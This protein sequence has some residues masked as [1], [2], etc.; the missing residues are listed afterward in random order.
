MKTIKNLS[1]LLFLLGFMETALLLGC[2]GEQG[3]PGPKAEQGTKGDKGDPGLDGQKGDKGETGETGQVGQNGNANVI[4][5]TYEK[6]YPPNPG[7]NFS[8][9]WEIS[10]ADIEKSLLFVYIQVEGNTPTSFNKGVWYAVPG[11]TSN[12]PGDT[13]SSQFFS[14]VGQF[15][16]TRVSGNSVRMITKTKAI[17]IPAAKL[18]NLRQ[19]APEIDYTDYNA[20]KKAFNLTD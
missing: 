13:F 11:S 18:Y 15:D 10:I 6:D 9:P 7:S 17:L 4:Q 8:F 20:V 19:A 12:T 14:S 1:V 3:E 5:I 16:V 2:K